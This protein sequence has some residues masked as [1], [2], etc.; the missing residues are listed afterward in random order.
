MPDTVLVILAVIFVLGIAINI[1]EFG[2]FLVAKLFGMRVEA[3]SFFGLGPRVWG[4]KV[5][6]TDYRISAIPLGAYVKLYG[7]EATASLEGGESTDE[8]VPES[9]LYELR[10]RWQKFLV[11][12]GGPFMNIMLA[13]S[14]PFAGALIYG[15]PSIASPVVASVKEGGS[16]QQAGIQVG[17]R[18]VGFDG[19]ENPT[20]Q[21]IDNDSKISP[22]RSIPVVV[23]RNGSKV[24]LTVTPTRIEEKGNVIGSLDL[25]PTELVILS[26]QPG[27][28]AEASGVQKGDKALSINGV[29]VTG[30]KSFRDTIQEGKGTP[31]QLTVI[32]NNQPTQVTIEPKDDGKGQFLIGAGIS[33]QSLDKEKATIAQCAAFAFN[34]NL[35]IVRLTGRVFGQLFTGQRSVKDAGLSGPVGIVSL[36][37]QI[38]R[39]AGFAGLVSVLAVISLNLGVFNLLPIPLLDGGQIMVLAIEKVMSW[40]GRTLSMAWKERIQLTGLA[41]ILMLIV[42]VTFLDLSRFF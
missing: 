14:I 3:Y 26:P 37:A 5:G 28:P 40:F 32:R 21:R 2:H 11:M 23:E 1:H 20:W 31:V 8:T 36:I 25:D 4:F 9:E 39:E 13:L 27:S 6:H 15:V 17:D 38:V 19:K 35:E 34:A 29:T 41:V 7:D 33:N 12:L 18:I 24:D 16:A 22:E 10:P 42:F 30:V